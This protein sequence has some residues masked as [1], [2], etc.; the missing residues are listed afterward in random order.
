MSPGSNTESYLA[1]AHT[2]LRENPGKTSTSWLF[3]DAVSTT[4]LFSVDEIG[5]SEMIFGEINRGFAIDYLAF[6]LQLGKT[7]EKAQPVVK[8]DASIPKVEEILTVVRK[9]GFSTSIEVEDGG[10]NSI[11]CR[12]RGSFY[13]KV[14][15]RPEHGTDR[16]SSSTVSSD[17]PDIM[18]KQMDRHPIAFIRLRVVELPPYSPDLASSDYNMFRQL[19]K[20]LAGQRLI[21]DDDAKT[22]VR[23]CFL[24]LPS[25]FYKSGISKLVRDVIDVHLPCGL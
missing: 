14:F 11:T 4:R 2:G 8:F 5:G 19:K 25:K 1:F 6:N 18:S 17:G 7:S 22:P 3:N 21:S 24:V 13:D 10:S 23:R 12:L 16:N 9:L 20:L 15:H